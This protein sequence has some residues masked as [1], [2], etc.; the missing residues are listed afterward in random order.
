MSFLFT[1]PNSFAKTYSQTFLSD[2]NS[3]WKGLLISLSKY[4]LD[5]NDQ[6]SGEI[7]TS[8][9]KPGVAFTP[10]NRIPNSKEAYQLFIQI[11]KKEL[12]N[13]NTI[14][15]NV[16]KKAFIKGDF[17]NKTQD[18]KSDGVEE[19]IVLYRTTREIKI[20]KAIQKNFN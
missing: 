17:I 10:L 15:V 14:L 18:L 2:Y 13:K 9:I 6:E 3:V 19:S 20:D 4:P 5:K 8:L 7:V 1:S 11:Q 12:N 16:E